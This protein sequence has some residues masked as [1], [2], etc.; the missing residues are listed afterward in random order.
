MPDYQL[1]RSEEDWSGLCRQANRRDDFWD[2]LKCSGRG[3]PWDSPYALIALAHTVAGRCTDDSHRIAFI[4]CTKRFMDLVVGASNTFLGPPTSIFST[5]AMICFAS[6]GI[7]PV[8]A[9]RVRLRGHS[10]REV[11]SASSFFFSDR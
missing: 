3:R 10:V 4:G 8:E 2:P 11:R 9:L 5:G 6:N 1:D 7:N